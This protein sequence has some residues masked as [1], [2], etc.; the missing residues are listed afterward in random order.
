MKLAV[1]FIGTSKYLN[2][3]P[4]WYEGCEKYLAPNTD[5]QYFVFTDGEIEGMPDNVNAFSQEHLPW[6]RLHCIDGIPFSKQEST[7]KV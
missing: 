3:L 6:H 4:T 1:I 5:K 2:F 7:G